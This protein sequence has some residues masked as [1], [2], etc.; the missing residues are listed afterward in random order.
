[1]KAAVLFVPGL[2][3]CL[4]FHDFVL[5]SHWTYSIPCEHYLKEVSMLP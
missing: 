2:G 4:L 3:T 5:T 1:M